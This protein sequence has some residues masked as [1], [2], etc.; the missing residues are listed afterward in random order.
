M[1]SAFARI[2]CLPLALVAGAVHVMVLKPVTAQIP[3]RPAPEPAPA[4]A[5]K[6][7]RK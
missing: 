5:R 7:A 6:G 3:E 4:V 1:G 2:S